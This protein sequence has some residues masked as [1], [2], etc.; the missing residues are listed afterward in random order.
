MQ[1]PIHAEGIDLPTVWIDLCESTG[2][3]LR[4]MSTSIDHGYICF[5]WGVPV[6]LEHPVC[7]ILAEQP[8]LD[9]FCS[10][11][12]ETSPEL[13]SIMV[14]SSGRVVLV[15]LE[16]VNQDSIA[17]AVKQ[18]LTHSLAGRGLDVLINDSGINE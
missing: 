13:R 12:S 5:K 2:M 9:N 3:F 8:G 6:A 15:P 17:A 10:N 1:L 7:K 18:R 16:V 14:K 4:R 11:R